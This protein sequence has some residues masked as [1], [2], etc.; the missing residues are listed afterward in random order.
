MYLQQRTQKLLRQQ[1]KNIMKR[2]NIDDDKYLEQGA[3]EMK[4]KKSNEC[5]DGEAEYFEQKLKEANEGLASSQFFI[6][7][8]YMLGFGTIRSTKTAIEWYQKAAD[9]IVF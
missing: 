4:H 7:H 9:R 2:T 6:G 3:D 5:H 8:C 1:L